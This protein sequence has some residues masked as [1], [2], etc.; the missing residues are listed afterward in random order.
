MERF[1][2]IR[3]DASQAD[4]ADIQVEYLLMK[5][6]TPIWGRVPVGLTVGGW[7]DLSD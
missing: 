6:S 5:I 7:Q 3:T 4:V 1:H 2:V